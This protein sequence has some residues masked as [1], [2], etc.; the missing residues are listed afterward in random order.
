MSAFNYSPIAYSDSVFQAVTTMENAAKVILTPEGQQ[1]TAERWDKETPYL[2]DLIVGNCGRAM[3]EQSWLLDYGCGIGRNA[4]PMINQ[5]GCNVVGVD[6]SNTM[7]SF[8]VAYVD[9]PRFLCCSPDMLQTLVSRWNVRFDLAISVW[10]L[11]H[12]QFPD[13]EL[14]TIKRCLRRSGRLFVVEQKQRAVPT[15]QWT[16]ADDRLDVRAQIESAF[17]LE[18]CGALDTDIVPA[19]LAERAYWAVYRNATPSRDGVG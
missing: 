1:S 7:R 9:S 3:N 16:F 6:I 13:K 14:A 15:E 11:Q 18:K 12:C 19:E 2:I 17:T 8:A 5:L 4:L 10:V